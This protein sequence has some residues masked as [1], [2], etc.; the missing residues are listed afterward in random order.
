[1]AIGEVDAIDTLTAA[2]EF[3]RDARLAERAVE[4]RFA[5]GDLGLG[6]EAGDFAQPDA[7][8]AGYWARLRAA[9]FALAGEAAAAEVTL[10][11]AR[12]RG[13][14]LVDDK[15]TAL[16]LRAAGAPGPAAPRSPRDSVELALALAGGVS[17]SEEA[18]RE[19]PP[20]DAV[21]IARNPDL[22]G[23]LRMAAASAAPGALTPSETAAIYQA[24]AGAPGEG[25]DE[26]LR[27]ATDIG[28]PQRAA[29]L[30]RM[31]IAADAPGAKAAAIAEALA[32]TTGVADFTVAAQLYA[33]ELAF[34]PIDSETLVHA[35][36]FIEALAAAGDPRLARTW[37]RG[38]Q[39]GMPDPAATSGPIALGPSGDEE[40]DAPV[41]ALPGAGDLAAL[42]AL[43]E[44]SDPNARPEA[45]GRA[46]RE[47]LRAATVADQAERAAA[48]RDAAVLLALGAEASPA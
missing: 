6:C 44:A 3:L 25:D 47:R 19:L 35:P 30:H 22:A 7:A 15:F 29:F 9:C 45:L 13:A 5:R 20:V 32:Q 2:A 12:E 33:P 21:A 28:D 43:V 48:E 34:L 18:A 10:D 36:A 23:P 8:Q 46:A 42:V 39:R 17:I 37:L 38:L 41:R 27:R 11:L 26:A 1:A 14:D 24:V 4:A 16:A 40:G 31:V